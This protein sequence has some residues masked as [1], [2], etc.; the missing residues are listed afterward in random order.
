MH[1]S[2][3]RRNEG[4]RRKNRALPGTRLNRLRAARQP[5]LCSLE[6]Y[7][8]CGCS[9]VAFTFISFFSR[10]TVNVTSCDP[11]PDGRAAVS[12][13]ADATVRP[14]TAVIT[15]PAFSPAL[16]AAESFCTLD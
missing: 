13:D 6:H 15:S 8:E 16:S 9:G 5:G 3:L 2:P 14:S 11:S 10:T 7:T 12:C 1:W 4:G